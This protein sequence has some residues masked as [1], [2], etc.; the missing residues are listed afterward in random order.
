MNYR[1]AKKIVNRYQSALAHLSEGQSLTDFQ[2]PGGGASYSQGQVQKAC[3]IMKISLQDVMEAV[4]KKAPTTSAKKP[5]SLTKPAGP[6]TPN[7]TRARTEEGTY[8]AD[9]PTTPNT[10]EAWAGGKDP[11]D[12]TVKELRDM[13][14]KQGITGYSRMTKTALIQ[15]LS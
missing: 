15:V 8:K 1:I 13:A 10:N 11:L 12:Y 9:D 6:V 4:V 5:I 7:L 3:R 14:K 2:W